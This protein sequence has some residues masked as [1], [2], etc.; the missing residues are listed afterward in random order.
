MALPSA[1]MIQLPNQL[2]PRETDALTLHSGDPARFSVGCTLPAADEHGYQNNCNN[3]T[4]VFIAL[5]WFQT[6][7]W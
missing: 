1:Y 2:P 4:D 5:D 6:F 7:E 3:R